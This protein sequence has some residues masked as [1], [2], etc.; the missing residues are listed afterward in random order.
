MKYEVT[1]WM[2]SITQVV[3][4][5]SPQDA[6]DRVMDAIDH[7]EHVHVSDGEPYREPELTQFGAIKIDMV[8]GVWYL[9]ED[10]SE[11]T[12]DEVRAAWHL[13]TPAGTP[14]PIDGGYGLR[15]LGDIRDEI[16]IEI[17]IRGILLKPEE[18]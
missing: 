17:E 14:R 1:I 16:E 5:E 7:F 13:A 4:A 12:D 6:R 11:F 9:P 3:E 18:A 15:V 2:E 8:S 10:W